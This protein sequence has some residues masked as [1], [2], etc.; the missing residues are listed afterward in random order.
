MIARRV[1]CLIKGGVIFFKIAR[2]AAP[3]GCAFL[4]V[5]LDIRHSSSLGN[6]QPLVTAATGVRRS[7]ARCENFDCLRLILLHC[8]RCLQQHGPGFVSRPTSL[9]SVSG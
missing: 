8:C 3:R 7:G 9:L 1:G 5:E 2:I 4:A 6:Y